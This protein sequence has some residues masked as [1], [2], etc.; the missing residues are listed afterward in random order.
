M[1]PRDDEWH[2]DEKTGEMTDSPTG[3]SAEHLRQARKKGHC[4]LCASHNTVRYATGRVQHRQCKNCG[5]LFKV[6]KK[7]QFWWE[8]KGALD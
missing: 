8:K 6:G 7:K 2:R 1:D 5:A 4:P 3:F